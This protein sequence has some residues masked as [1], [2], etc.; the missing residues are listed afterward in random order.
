MAGVISVCKKI[1]ILF[2]VV[3]TFATLASCVINLSL[4]FETDT[5]SH[6][7]DRAALSLMG[8][9]II[10][11]MLELNFK[12]GVL[13][14]LIP[15]AIFMSLAFLY[16]FI[17]GFFSELHPNAYRDI[18]LNDTIAYIV[19]YIGLFVYSKIKQPKTNKNEKEK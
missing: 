6:I 17:S 2:C 16:V 4:S 10:T 9:I 14:F 19:V 3:F 11:I 15:Y 12:N 1:L 13:K 5:Y 7:L 8:C 18:F